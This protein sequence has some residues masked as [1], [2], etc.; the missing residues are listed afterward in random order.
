[1]KHPVIDYIGGSRQAVL[2]MHEIFSEIHT[3]NIDSDDKK[4]APIQGALGGMQIWLSSTQKFSN[5]RSRTT[6]FQGITGTP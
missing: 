2:F 1:M 4:N 5:M 3:L 6:L